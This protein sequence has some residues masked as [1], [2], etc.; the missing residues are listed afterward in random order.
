[1]QSAE[2]DNPVSASSADLPPEV[3]EVNEP[4]F[5]PPPSQRG[6][7]QP[8]ARLR[9]HLGAGA[10][11]R[12]QT[13]D[14]KVMMIN[15]FLFFFSLGTLTIIAN[16]TNAKANE[17]VYKTKKRRDDGKFYYKVFMHC[18]WCCAWM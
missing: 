3:E 7:G 11:R 15:L 14:V 12:G 10:R 2:P 9:E 6:E 8:S 1:M 13:F 17:F 16:F 4:T 5:R 18:V